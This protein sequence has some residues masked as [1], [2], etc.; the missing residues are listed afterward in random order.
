MPLEW[1]QG[2]D[3]A[4]SQL[5]KII[6][7]HNFPEKIFPKDVALLVIRINHLKIHEI[8]HNINQHW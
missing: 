4:G 2:V 6:T 1:I 3:H 7:C 5:G 8:N